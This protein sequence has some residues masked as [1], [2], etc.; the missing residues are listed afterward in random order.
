MVL[1]VRRLGRRRAGG[2]ADPADGV[3]PDRAGGADRGRRLRRAQADARRGDRA[4]VR[5][6]PA[7]RG[8]DGDR[9]RRSA[10]T[11]ARSGPGT[12]SFFVF[13]LV[14]LLGY[15]F[16]EAS[17]KARLANWATNLAAL[18]VFVPQGAVLWKVGLLMGAVQ[19]G[20]RLRRRPHR[21]RR[22]APVRAGVLHRRG[23]G[24][25]RPDRRRRLR[26]VVTT[27]GRACTPDLAH[28]VHR[29]P[30][31]AYDD[32]GGV[33]GGRH[34]LPRDTEPWRARRV[35][36]AGAAGGRR[37]PP[38]SQR[39]A[40]GPGRPSRPRRATAAASA[41]RVP[42]SSPAWACD[43]LAEASSSASC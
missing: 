8:R 28:R 16:L 39:I 42:R 4:A 26:G 36:D 22:G 21:G 27:V 18:C 2:V 37:L 32:G 24:L 25:H 41:V 7:H 17:A 20:R 14:G 12:G 33:L 23:L 5:R 6:P 10:S 40:D 13:T 30:A 35:R 38:A 1:R 3:R 19:P 29:P 31:D 34:R 9:P 43:Y 15:N 11:T